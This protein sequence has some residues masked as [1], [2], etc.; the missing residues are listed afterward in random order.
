M[1]GQG[2][3]TAI[4]AAVAVS[5]EPEGSATPAYRTTRRSL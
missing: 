3:L 5:P 1:V 4:G 2:A